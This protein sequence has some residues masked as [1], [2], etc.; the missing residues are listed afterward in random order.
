MS[1]S[2]EEYTKHDVPKEEEHEYVEITGSKLRSV[3]YEAD[4]HS[5]SYD[6]RHDAETISVT[7]LDAYTSDAASIFFGDTKPATVNRKRKPLRNY[8]DNV[9]QSEYDC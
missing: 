3:T 7:S 1:R 9:S 5:D 6:D 8:E 2:N 4:D